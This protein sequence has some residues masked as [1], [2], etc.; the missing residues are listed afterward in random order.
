MHLR[1]LVLLALVAMLVVPTA[2]HAKRRSVAPNWAPAESASIQPGV[3]TFTDG[4]GQCTANFVFSDSVG[5]VYIGQA[6]HCA[7]TGEATDTNGCD[8]GSL[9]LGTQV[10]VD[11]ASLPGTIVYSSWLTMQANDEQDVNACRF[12]DFALIKLDPADRGAVNPSVPVFGGPVSLGAATDLGDKVYS[13]GN[14]GLRFGLSPTSP[15]EG[16]SVGQ[17]GGG[18]NHTVYTASPGI[19]GDSGSAFLSADG[20]ALGTLSTVAFLPFPASNGVS[21]L[22]REVA[23]MQ[24]FGGFSGIQLALGTE[25]FTGG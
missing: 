24:Q 9:P 7:G 19:P 5:D 20:A 11:G 13:Y 1:K 17:N 2:A 4:S 16:Y 10:E 18:W 21:D 3:Q 23:Y 6:A 8:A 25:P 14:S 22:S 15:K 12:N